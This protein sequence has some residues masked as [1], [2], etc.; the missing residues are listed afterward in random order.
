MDFFGEIKELFREE[1]I[2]TR[3]DLERWKNKLAKKYRMK[4]PRNSEILRRLDDDLKEKYR[5]ILVKKP[6][7]TLSG[8]AIVAVMT[9]P[10]PCPH[11][12]CIYCPGGPEMGTAQ[13]YT[14]HEPAALRAGQHNFD[15]YMQ[16]RARIE[17][18]N[19]IGHPTDKVDLII[20]GGTF[21]ARPKNYQEWFIKR[22]FDSLNNCD[23][24]DLNEA[25]LINEYAKNRC[26]GLTVETRPDWFYEKEIDFSLHL[27]ATRVEL[28]IQT[29]Y[30]D[31]LK[32]VKRGHGIKESILST[33][34]AKD[35]GFKINYHMM[36]GLPGSDLNKDYL[37]F[38][39]IFE[40]EKFKPDM[41]KIYPTLVI[42]GTELYEMWKRGDY[43][44]YTLEDMIELLIR[45]KKIVP[46]WIRIQRI[47]RDVPAKFIE[48][49]VK[50]SDL[51]AIV[52]REMEKRGEKCRC[53]RCREV[54]RRGGKN[55]KLTRRN[56]R[57]SG[58]KEI[59]LSHEDED[60]DSIASYLRLRFPSE[61]AHRSEVRNA[62]IIREVKVFGKEIPI[63][64]RDRKAW[65]HRG[66]GTELMKEA[67]RIAKEELGVDRII[68]ISGI[69]VRDYYRRLGYERLGPYM[70]KRINK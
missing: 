16:V 41:L 56:Y 7:R 4:M 12:K 36:P 23:A 32:R 37:A 39:R 45:V 61:H 28:G 20:M 38:K 40:D 33:Q 2:K 17:Q 14:G 47:Q 3:G 70:G 11:G 15:P 29:V 19:D 13:S 65:Q 53:I 1:R 63:G 66:L 5:E 68:V 42:K 27:G 57:A 50:K 31:I 51:R 43:E 22:T 35:A 67:E 58:G 8:V 24:R 10:F 60:Y 54:G 25:Q 26:I 59:F 48:A 9:S 49:G 55:F 62:A 52:Q 34:L 21:T 18:L 69:G 6:S 64:E 30:D 44:P 46:P